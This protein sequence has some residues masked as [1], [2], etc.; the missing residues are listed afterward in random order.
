MQRCMKASMCA[1]M[2]EVSQ[3]QGRGLRAATAVAVEVYAFFH[4]LPVRVN[5]ISFKNNLMTRNTGHTTAGGDSPPAIIS[6]LHQLATAF[7]T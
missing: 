2:E 4:S 6:I 7:K 5:D 1:K 3:F